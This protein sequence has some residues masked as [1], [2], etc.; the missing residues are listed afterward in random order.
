MLI[1]CY[2]LKVEVETERVQQV[3]SYGTKV[4]KGKKERWV[5]SGDGADGEGA[6]DRGEGQGS[7]ATHCVTV[8]PTPSPS[9]SLRITPIS[10]NVAMSARHDV[11]TAVRTHCWAP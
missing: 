7:G 8:K 9:S 4:S 11:Y 5:G 3:E 1:D 10:L 2:G 6:R